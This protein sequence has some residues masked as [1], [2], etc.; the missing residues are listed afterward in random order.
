[1]FRS[2]ITDNAKHTGLHTAAAWGQ[3][4]AIQTLVELGDRFEANERLKNKPSHSAALHDQVDSI[5]MLKKLGADLEAVIF[6]LWILFLWQPQG[7]I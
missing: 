5:I 1:M 7:V 6:R 4:K 3:I 2:K